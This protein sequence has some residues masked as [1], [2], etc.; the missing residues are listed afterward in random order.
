MALTN[1]EKQARY[2]Q[3]NLKDGNRERLQVV[4]SLHARRALERLAQ[5]HG[6]TLAGIVERLALEEAERVTNCM[7]AD[8]F[9]RF[10]GE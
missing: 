10:V 1:A 6:L 3:K 9:R 2:R 7:D 8:Q 4:V 5:H